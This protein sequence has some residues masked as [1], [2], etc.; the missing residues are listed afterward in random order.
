MTAAVEATQKGGLPMRSNRASFLGGV[1]T[2]A[3]GLLLSTSARAKVDAP[4]RQGAATPE[5]VQ[6]LLLADV[7]VQGQQPAPTPA[8]APAAPAPVVVEPQTQA[9][10]VAPAHSSTVVEHENRNYMETIAVSALMGAVAGVLVG[11]A[12][13]YLADNRTHAPRILYWGAGGVL[14]GTA[15]GL[16]Q[17]AVQESRV[18]RATASRLPN[19]PAPTLRLALLQKSF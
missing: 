5:R 17:L 18:D 7:V 19:D 10:V 4:A 15:V 16:T 2:L 1:L 9:P 13:Y 14:V 12:I 8:P 6:P 3:V 11:G